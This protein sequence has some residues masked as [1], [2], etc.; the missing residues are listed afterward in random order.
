[1]ENK[2]TTFKHNDKTFELR[3]DSN[4]NVWFKNDKGYFMR[5]RVEGEPIK[6]IKVAKSLFI[7]LLSK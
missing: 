2:I 6:S 5:A 1:M 7:N 4:G 3:L